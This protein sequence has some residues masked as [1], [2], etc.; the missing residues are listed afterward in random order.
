MRKNI[1]KH[2]ILLYLVLI[3]RYLVLETSNDLLVL[4]M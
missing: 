2:V 3:T 1:D 4:T